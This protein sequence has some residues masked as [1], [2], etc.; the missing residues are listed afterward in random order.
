MGRGQ[1]VPNLWMN[2][3]GAA[4]FDPNISHAEAVARWQK[5][6]DNLTLSSFAEDYRR[7]LRD[8]AT[9]D[10]WAEY[11]RRTRVGQGRRDGRPGLRRCGKHSGRGRR[12]LGCEDCEAAEKAA[13]DVDRIASD[14]IAHDEAISA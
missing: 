7:G 4:V 1:G 8:D 13:Q 3:A 9:V 14:I 10:A 12:P 11:S 6:L 5:S 2:K